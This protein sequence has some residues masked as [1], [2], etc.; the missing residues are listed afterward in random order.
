MRLLEHFNGVEDKSPEAFLF[1]QHCQPQGR[2]RLLHRAFSKAVKKAAADGVIE[3]DPARERLSLHSF[4]H[5]VTNQLLDAGVPPKTMAEYLGDDVQT[6]LA[7]STHRNRNV[8][9][10]NIAALLEEVA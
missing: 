5:A 4:R 10:G 3:Y 7:Y 1:G 8:G 6:I 2:Y 9:S